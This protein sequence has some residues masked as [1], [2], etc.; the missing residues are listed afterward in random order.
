MNN[1]RKFIPV[2]IIGVLAG[3]LDNASSWLL[4]LA[5]IVYMLVFK[6]DKS[7]VSE[8]VVDARDSGVMTDERTDTLH[9]EY[10][11][12]ERANEK[13][14]FH[15]SSEIFTLLDE[16]MLLVKN[17]EVKD[18]LQSIKEATKLLLTPSFASEVEQ[19]AMNK[20]ETFY[21]PKTIEQLT[22]YKKLLNK[23]TL[24]E[25]QH[26]AMVNVE[27]AILSISK[28]FKEYIASVGSAEAFNME[29]EAKAIKQMVDSDV[30]HSDF[31]WRS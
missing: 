17:N 19:S 31:D 10:L 16:L 9:H 7:E 2:I 21:L 1:I 23:D 12:K 18:A 20:F 24:N 22:Y 27:E 26:S 8:D 4:L 28:I 6:R 11:P 15:E 14:T 13:E 30:H 3:V 25:A 5:I 29:A